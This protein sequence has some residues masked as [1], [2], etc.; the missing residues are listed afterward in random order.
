MPTLL[1]LNIKGGLGSLLRPLTAF[2]STLD[3]DVICLQECA[4][5]VV[6]WLQE[7]L[8]GTWQ[9]TWAEATY[10]GNAILTRHPIATSRTLSLKTSGHAETRS[11]VDAVIDLPGGALRV[12]CTH[13]DHVLEPTRLAQWT[14][15]SA[16]T[17]GVAGGVLCG[18]LNALRR[19][20][21]TDAEWAKITAERAEGCWELPRHDL[22]DTLLDAGFQD[23]ADG[24]PPEPTSRFGTRIDY[25]LLAPGCPWRAVEIATLPTLDR[26]ITDHNGVL[27]R[28]H[29]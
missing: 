24:T 29:R 13:L 4:G 12:C 10:N 5:P 18:D 11:A 19:S 3:V 27:V 28:L 7:Q 22:L 23:A 15:L 8:D 16:Q 6:P 26:G 9:A 2:L 20:D 25:V 14:A 21:Y 1:S 17:G